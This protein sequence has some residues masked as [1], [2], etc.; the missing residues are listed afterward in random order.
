[1]LQGY[2]A[3]VPAMAFDAS[4]SAG[5]SSPGSAQQ[6]DY[7][8]AIDPALEA[9][10]APQGAP[11]FTQGTEYFY[12]DELARSS[13]FFSSS[14]P[15]SS[16]PT[17][18][19]PK[20]SGYTNPLQV[21]GRSRFASPPTS[22]SQV[23]HSQT[24]ALQAGDTGVS[25]LRPL[26][27]PQLSKSNSQ[28]TSCVNDAPQVKDSNQ[29]AS[30]S[31]EQSKEQ[32]SGRN[33]RQAP[34][35]PPKKPG[36]LRVDNFSPNRLLALLSNDGSADLITTAKPCKVD[37]LLLK[38]P[39]KAEDF[40][41]EQATIDEIKHLWLS[42]YVNGL[43]SFLESRFYYTDG[44]EYLLKDKIVM[45]QFAILL[46]QF[47]KAT[48][49]NP[50]EMLYTASIEGR[51]VW[52]LACLVRSA[53]EVASATPAP[54]RLDGIPP[55]EDPI[56]AAARL[57]VFENLVTSQIAEGNSLTKP[58]TTG[59]Y[60]KLREMEFWFHLGHFVT[61]RLHDNDPGSAKEVDE[62]L[63][64]LRS[65]LD[66]RENRDVLYSIAIV[67][68]IGQ[69]VSEYVESEAPLHLDEQDTRSKLMV[70]KRFV[71]DEGN[72]AGTTNVIRR[73]CELAS[74]PWNP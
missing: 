55:A 59:D 5:V 74:R 68:A 3:Q 62:T 47:A 64:A 54:P 17:P 50:A 29:K 21:G 44:L 43:E 4:L 14:P 71:R 20:T 58:P 69:R 38:L 22:D 2:G 16:P 18:C 39:S 36:K 27:Q 57:A 32:S 19:P 61:L 49:D 46:N 53:A 28:S 25:K 15:S 26:N 56:E 41:P 65:L 35:T 9:V 6:F 31:K 73:F 13:P 42:I 63:A 52:S 70:A 48:P 24:A 51:V 60:H 72:G 23:A 11:Q 1:M 66:G 33:K 30:I 37:D 67:R 7:S 12:G 34:R 8:S 10:A 45:E 40:K